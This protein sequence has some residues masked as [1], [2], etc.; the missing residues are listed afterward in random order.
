MWTFKLVCHVFFLLGHFGA[1]VVQNHAGPVCV[2]R[3]SYVNDGTCYDL[4]FELFKIFPLPEWL[5]CE[6]YCEIEAENF[7]LWYLKVKTLE[8]ARPF[9]C[10]VGWESIQ[11]SSESIH[12]FVFPDEH[13]SESES[14]SASNSNSESEPDTPREVVQ[15]SKREN[16]PDDHCAALKPAELMRLRVLF[17]SV[18]VDRLFAS[19]GQLA[20]LMNAVFPVAGRLGEY[21]SLAPSNNGAEQNAEWPFPTS[22]TTSSQEGL[23][24]S[25]HLNQPGMCIPSTKDAAAETTSLDLLSWYTCNCG[26]AFRFN[27]IL[28]T[29]PLGNPRDDNEVLQSECNAEDFARDLAGLPTEWSLLPDSVVKRWTSSFDTTNEEAQVASRLEIGF[30]CRTRDLVREGSEACS[31]LLRK[32][33]EWHFL[34]CERSEKLRKAREDE[35]LKRS[36][37]Y[38]DPSD[39]CRDLKRPRAFM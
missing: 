35:R 17:I 14:G 38:P 1:C 18:I 12:G 33:P 28:M 37:G 10:S 22:P 23:N 31:A 2:S 13:S 19:L 3:T 25:S 32:E 5:D 21:L 16:S 34:L 39:Q 15:L 9:V 20:T 26:L 7:E 29:G 11:W 27:R 30:L 4:E 8:Q 24:H 36:G 6:I